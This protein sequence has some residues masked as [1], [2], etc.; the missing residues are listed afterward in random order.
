[1]SGW[2]MFGIL[3]VKRMVGPFGFVGPS[4]I[5]T[6]K[7]WTIFWLKFQATKVL[8]YAGDEE[9]IALRSGIFSSNFSVL[10]GVQSSLL[11]PSSIIWS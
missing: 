3:L 9:I 2:Q 4:L 7:A 8:K 10:F 11:F 6:W 5:G 1:M